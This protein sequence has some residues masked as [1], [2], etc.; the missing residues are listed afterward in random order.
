MLKVTTFVSHNSFENFSLID[1]LVNCFIKLFSIDIFI[2]I[3]KIKYFMTSE[4]IHPLASDYCDFL[5][6]NMFMKR[7]QSKI[8]HNEK[9]QF[10]V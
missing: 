7:L 2:K 6:L 4:K 10:Y 5:A 1:G 9:S 3:V 8:L